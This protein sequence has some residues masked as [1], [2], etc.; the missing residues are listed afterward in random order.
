[1]IND[2]IK[3]SSLKM[4]DMKF[5]NEVN[6]YLKTQLISKEKCG[7]TKK[8]LKN[9]FNKNEIRHVVNQIKNERYSFRKFSTE[10]QID[11]FN[12]YMIYFDI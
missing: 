4:F 7:R 5:H 3:T 6:S 9:Q 10:E 12:Q 1:M 11:Y 8:L 2:I